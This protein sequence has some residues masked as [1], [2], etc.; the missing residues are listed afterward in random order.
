MRMLGNCF[1]YIVLVCLSQELKNH[2]KEECERLK[3]A[4]VAH[5]GAI[6]LQ[7]TDLG[8]CKVIGT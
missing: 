3:G 6:E 8:S 4:I 5:Q 7:V 1:E 2:L